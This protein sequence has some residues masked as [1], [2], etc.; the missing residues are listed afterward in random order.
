MAIAIGALAA[1]AAWAM[2]AP[3][4]TALIIGLATGLAFGVLEAIGSRVA[5]TVER[6]HTTIEGIGTRVEEVQ[7][8]VHDIQHDIRRQMPLPS[9]PNAPPDESK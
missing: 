5:S 9:T 3:Y 8:D 7:R 2:T 6:I 4:L 1:Y